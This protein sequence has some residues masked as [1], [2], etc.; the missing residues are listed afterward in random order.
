MRRWL[1]ALK[2]AAIPAAAAAGVPVTMSA[3]AAPAAVQ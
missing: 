3:A 2:P 1:E